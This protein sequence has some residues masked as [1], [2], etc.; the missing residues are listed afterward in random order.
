MFCAV[1]GRKLKSEQSKKAGY[2]PVCYKK[3]FGD[4]LQDTSKGNTSKLEDL[5]C[6]DIPGQMTIEEYIQTI[7]K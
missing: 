5:P 7:S 3:K 6:Y 4:S 1:C 2:G